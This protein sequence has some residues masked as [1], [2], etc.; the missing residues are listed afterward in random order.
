V[1][2]EAFIRASRATTEHLF[3]SI[4]VRDLFVVQVS[5]IT[6][7]ILQVWQETGVDMKS[8][9]ENGVVGCPRLA[10]GLRVGLGVDPSHRSPAEGPR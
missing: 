2:Y 10:T 5:D 1:R 3:K 4:M 6:P 8:I 7:L 9:S